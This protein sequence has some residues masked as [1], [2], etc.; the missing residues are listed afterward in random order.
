MA[1]EE[2]NVKLKDLNM[3]IK[4]ISLNSCYI[5]NKDAIL[6]NKEISIRKRFDYSAFFI[7]LY[8]S[9]EKFVENLIKVYVQQLT[10]H[11]PYESLPQKLQK[12]HLTRSAQMLQ[13]KLQGNGDD[14][15]LRQ[16]ALVQNLFD[17]L[18]G[19]ET[20]ALNIDAVINNY[21]NLKAS[22][23][24]DIFNIIDLK[25]IC[26]LVC[27]TNAIKTWYCD[28]NKLDKDRLKVVEREIIDLR[29]NDIINY[30]NQIAHGGNLPD[31][32]P[33]SESLSE[34][35]KFIQSLS[36]SLF[37]LVAGRYLFTRYSNS[38]NDSEPVNR[39]ELMLRK[40]NESSKNTRWE[41][42]RID[43]PPPKLITGQPVFFIAND[44]ETLWGRIQRL[45]VDDHFPEELEVTSKENAP[46]DLAI[47]LD[48]QSPSEGGKLIALDS[49]D[50]L[51]WSPS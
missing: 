21:G 12:K 18:S 35:L 9:F 50:D 37:E 5:S 3:L 36:K 16:L 17:C 43:A 44:H 11:F 14:L 49:D 32:L 15:K 7:I 34:L 47:E 48:F 10:R 51:V 31:N 26:N 13:G 46:A 42:S 45:L 22:I 4:P 24:D 6:T 20:Y 41:I 28:V 8:A 23:V 39:I 33:S 2:L 30:R 1:L 19:A 40:S 29:L 27:N 25:N 38:S